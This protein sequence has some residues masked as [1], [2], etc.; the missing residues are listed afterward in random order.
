MASEQQVQQPRHVVNA[1][2]VTTESIPTNAHQAP[3]ANNIYNNAPPLYTPSY[4][5]PNHQGS[6]TK[7][8]ELPAGWTTQTSGADGRI[9]Y[10][11]AAT[12][13]TS[14]THPHHT[15][16]TTVG[17]AVGTRI[18]GNQERMLDTPLNATR[19]PESH[20]CCACVSC[21]C[22]PPMGL[23]ALF[24]SFQTDRAWSDGRYGDAVNHSRQ[25]HNYAN[26][27]CFAGIALWIY[28]HFFVQGNG[29]NFDWGD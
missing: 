28:W 16:G 2:V 14:W 7:W 13:Q 12:G 25:A 21:M 17:T 9:Y 29:F 3:H 22:M 5:P 24:H 1:T 26:F 4:T 11:N 8:R 23:C 18:P 27:G 15:M 19:R 20:Q 6:V 10:H